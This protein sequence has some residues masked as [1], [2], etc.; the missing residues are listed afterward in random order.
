MHMVIIRLLS[1]HDRWG[2]CIYNVGQPHLELSLWWQGGD[3]SP[4]PPYGSHPQS[5]AHCQNHH[6]ASRSNG[7]VIMTGGASGVDGKTL[8]QIVKFSTSN[9]FHLFVFRLYSDYLYF[10]KANKSAEDFHQKVVESV[11]LFEACLSERSL[12]SCVYNTSL[13]HSMLVSLHHSVM[14][15][16][17]L[18]PQYV[19]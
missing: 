12:H 1:L 5:P 19:H 10:T 17:P 4:S 15:I 7:K 11:L 13:R 18:K 8:N 16:F 6:H 2:Q 14:F 9:L 3:K